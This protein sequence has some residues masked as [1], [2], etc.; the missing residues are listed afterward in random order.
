M[1]NLLKYFI[2]IF[3]LCLSVNTFSQEFACVE[4]INYVKKEGREIGSVSSIQLINSSW[5]KKVTC[6]NI[7]GNL[8]VIANIKTNDYSLY[9]KDYIFCG[10]TSYNWNAFNNS[11]YLL[12]STYGEL[13]HKYIFDYKCDCY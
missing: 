3:I 7:D 1:K 8:A 10:I 13:F 9:G 6:Y 2:G 5:L 12:N 4:L 11:L